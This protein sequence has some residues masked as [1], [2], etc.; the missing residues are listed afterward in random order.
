[1]TATIQLALGI[2]EV[3]DDVK[4]T[5]ARDGSASVATFYFEAPACL[6]Q[7]ANV[8]E[9]SGLYMTDEEGQ[10]ITRTVNA[11]YANGKLVR[12]EAI[13]KMSSEYEWERFL[14][15]MNRYAEANGLGFSKS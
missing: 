11:K 4:I 14:R 12:I 2:D 15:F 6:E 10:L 7:E 3:V 9:I 8:S 5:R 13:Y 1:M